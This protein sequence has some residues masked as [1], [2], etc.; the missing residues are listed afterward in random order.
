[1]GVK[2]S[3]VTIDSENDSDNDDVQYFERLP[4]EVMENV[5]CRLPILDLYLN[6][7]L[8]CK[9]WRDIIYDTKVMPLFRGLSF[10]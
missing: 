9:D 10:G 8:V 5:L 6:L 3:R 7:P 4:L 2:T 1:M